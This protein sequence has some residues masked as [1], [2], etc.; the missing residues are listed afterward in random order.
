MKENNIVAVSQKK[1]IHT[2]DS[3]HTNPVA[4]NILNRNFAL[5]EKNKA[6]VGDIT[7]IWTSRGFTYLSTVI[8]LYSRKIVSWSMGYLMTKKLV[9]EPLEDAVKH[10]KPENELIFHSDRGSQNASNDFKN[11]LSKN[12]VIQSMSR[13]GNCWD[14]AVAESFFKTIKTECLNRYKFRNLNEVERIVFEYIE[15]FYNTRRLHST[16]GYLS[17][18]EFERLN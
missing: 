14:N 9:I 1:F 16:L 3:K 18:N 17:P 7:Y 12:K 10:R 8:D 4:E 15:M 2:T 5:Q 11:S 6:W 13:K